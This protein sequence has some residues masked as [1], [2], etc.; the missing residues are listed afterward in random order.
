M[1]KK[2]NGMRRVFSVLLRLI[3]FGAA[4]L[5][6]VVL[7]AGTAMAAETKIDEKNFP[8]ESFR[9]WVSENADLD[10]NG[11][12][13][14]AEISKVKTMNIESSAIQ[15]LKGI[16]FFTE[17]EVMT[18]QG[19][20]SGRVDLRKNTKL[21]QL[22]LSGNYEMT[23]V[24]VSGCPELLYLD[25][26]YTMLRSLDIGENSKLKTLICDET[27]IQSLN[28]GNNKELTE[29]SCAE[30]K[31]TSLNL[32]KQTKLKSLVCSDNPITKLDLSKNV[33]LTSVDCARCA[34]TTL[35]IGSSL[36][37]LLKLDCSRNDLLSLDLTQAS[38]LN[39]LKVFGNRLSAKTLKLPNSLKELFELPGGETTVSRD[40]IRE[41]ALPVM[42]HKWDTDAKQI[43]ADLPVP[44]GDVISVVF[45]RGRAYG[46]EGPLYNTTQKAGK[47]FT[48]PKVT[49]I[50][51][52]YYFLGWSLAPNATEAQYKTG[53]KITL[54]RHSILYPVFKARTYKV[55]FN[56]NGGTSG[57]PAA[58]TGLPFDLDYFEIPAST[59]VRDGYYFMGWADAADPDWIYKSGDAYCAFNNKDVVLYAVWKPR[60]NKITFNANG[61][62]STVPAAISVLTGKEATVPSASVSRTGYWFLGW[63]T[64]KSAMAASYR[65]GDKISVTKDTVLYAV[66]K[67]QTT[68]NCTLTFDANGGTNPPAKITAAKGATVTI[69]SSS[70]SRSGYWFLGWA[71]S[72]TATSA[73]YKSGNTLTLS[74]NTTL[75]AVWKK[76]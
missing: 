2:V 23:S 66:W 18:V 63:S 31:I 43:T 56:L 53:D 70:V 6:C 29:L 5:L 38:K 35:T 76:K 4:A 10:G 73:Q 27:Q 40:Y 68:T 15:K 19:E 11:S 14:A 59:P 39:E 33:L 75:Y 42:I 54:Y 55:T 45:Y 9:E 44:V 57:A 8:D 25:V 61:G 65:S 13:S 17:L 30:T 62:S 26:S 20:L 3:T 72:K 24:D 48:I 41:L 16:E 64:D 36:K 32:S 47:E 69:P 21:K 28:L 60:T 58:I 67:S 71:T 7:L 51:N 37:E 22:D 52:Q 34:L 12:L 49:V 50:N 1:N 74:A 46:S